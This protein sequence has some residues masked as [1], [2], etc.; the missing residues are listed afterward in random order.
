MLGAIKKLISL[1]KVFSK[2]KIDLS[3]F[4][5]KIAD[6][7]PKLPKLKLVYYHPMTQNDPN[8]SLNVC[9]DAGSMIVVISKIF[10]LI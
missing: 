4:I 10:E 6:F 1:K 2:R 8:G 5:A 7:G 9:L 3:G